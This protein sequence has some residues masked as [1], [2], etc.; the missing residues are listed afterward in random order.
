M[1]ALRLRP[2]SGDRRDPA[3]GGL[4][5]PDDHGPLPRELRRRRVLAVMA[6]ALGALLAI[7]GSGRAVDDA[8]PVHLVEITG[9]IDLGLVPFLDRAITAAADDGA[10]ALVLRLDTPGGRLDAVLE[11]RSALL[12]S[13]VR[14]VA[15][16][17]REAFSAGALLA[18]AAEEIYFAPGGVMGAA[19]PVDGGTGAPADEKVVSAVRSTFR[20]TATERGRDP[21][22]AAAMVDADLEVAGVVEAGKLL[23]LTADEAREVGFSDGEAADLDALLEQLGLGDRPQVRTEQSLAESLVRIITNP[24]LASLLITVGVYLVIGDLLS[25]GVGAAAGVGVALLGTFFWGHLLAGLTGWEDIALVTVGVLLL[26][27][28]L[29]VVPGFG[30]FGVLGLGAVLG[31]T[32]LAMVNRDLDFVGTDQLVR[33]G[34]T[35]GAAFLAITVGVIATVSYLTR[36][37]GPPGLVLRT[38]LGASEPVTQRRGGGW[39]RWFGDGGSVLARETVH[40]DRPGDAGQ[41]DA[42]SDDPGPTRTATVPDAGT[43]RDGTVRRSLIGHAGTAL[44]DLR[45]AGIAEVDGERIDVVTEGGYLSAGEAIEVVRDEGYRRVVRR[46]REP[47]ASPPP[48]PPPPTPPAGDRP[49][50]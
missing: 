26:L 7:T 1:T 25:G 14:T 36:R 13:P 38:Q 5:A 44:S 17:D 4:P 41:D 11:M 6:L 16:V 43:A 22:V 40:T 42:A 47:P 31:G 18:I 9:E 15:F 48:S 39:L 27:I 3:R 29:L 19:T 33:A 46:R 20:A 35:V 8:A 37:G 2:A 24:V 12:G 28:E 32:F 50:G 10:A 45:P 34:A 21:A 30:V 23:T 49:L